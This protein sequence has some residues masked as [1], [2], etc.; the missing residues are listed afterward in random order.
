MLPSPD[1]DDRLKLAYEESLRAIRRQSERLDD[2]RSRAGITVTAGG[3]VAGF[4]ADNSRRWLLLAGAVAF[5]AVV[6]STVIILYP[7]RGWQFAGHP[8]RL[9]RLAEHEWVRDGDDYLRQSMTFL[10]ADYEGNEA[11]LKLLSRTLA[12]GILALGV[13]SLALMIARL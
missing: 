9:L 11:L 12:V 6:A 10:A 1:V 7:R 4:L 3:V 5:L 13:E 8:Q 2:L